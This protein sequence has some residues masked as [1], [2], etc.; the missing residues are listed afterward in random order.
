MFRKHFCFFGILMIVATALFVAPMF[1]ASAADVITLTNVHMKY[2]P[3]GQKSSLE[4]QCWPKT[5]SSEY[6]KCMFPNGVPSKLKRP[7]PNDKIQDE[8]MIEQID[9]NVPADS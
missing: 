8:T 1:V 9:P 4:N 5:N 6:A 3:R 7:D 2:G